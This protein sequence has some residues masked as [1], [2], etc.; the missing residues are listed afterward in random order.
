MIIIGCDF[1]SSFQQIAILDTESGECEE[2]KLMHATR[3]AEQ[4]YCRLGAPSLVGMES[5]GNS[6]CFVL[7]LEQ[8]GHEVRIGDDAQIR[9]SYVRKQKT[10]KRD[11]CH[12]LKL[13]VENRFP[14]IRV[15]DTRIRDQRQMLS[16]HKLVQIRTRVKNE[17]EHLMMNPGQ[18]NESK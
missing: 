3:V 10:Y 12:I 6:Q 16:R 13:L 11:A 17:L 1:H 18:N 7:L 2:R 9:A 14:R 5:V 8:L 15:P 4:F